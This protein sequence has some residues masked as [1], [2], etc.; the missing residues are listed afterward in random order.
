MSVLRKKILKLQLGRVKYFASL[1]MTFFLKHYFDFT[2][3]A[4]LT[5]N[6]LHQLILAER[7]ILLF[8]I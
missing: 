6:Y 1:K 2:L 8:Y 3:V 5:I 4:T 7:K